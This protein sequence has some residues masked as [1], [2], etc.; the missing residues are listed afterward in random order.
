MSK[1]SFKEIE[2][3]PPLVEKIPHGNGF[4][5][6]SPVPLADYAPSM[7]QRLREQARDI[8]DRDFLAE[9][10]GDGWRRVTYAQASAAA[11]SIAQAL[12]DRGC[13]PERPVMILSGNSV[14]H[15]LLLLGA[16]VA[17]I[18]V[19]PVSVAYSLMSQ[20]HSKL[21]HI[22]SEIRPRAIYV[23]NGKAFAAALAALDL[24]GV[25]IV[26][27][28]DAPDGIRATSFAD[29]VATKP[30]AAVEAAF[31]KVGP[32]TVAKIL[33][34]SGSTGMPKGVVNTQRM[35]AA[36]VMMAVQ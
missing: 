26:V 23:A 6:R 5:L 14:D 16:Y 25:E 17:G 33:Y 13:S 12:L 28:S 2:F 21:K 35:M 31:G 9:R 20:D 15:A 29:L 30:T 4:L 18:P 22:F 19:V 7:A 27:G 24:T 34:T 1:P 3:A 32:E 36:N 8:P 10:A 11:N